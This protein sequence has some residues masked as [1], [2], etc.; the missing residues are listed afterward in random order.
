MTPPETLRRG[1]IFRAEHD[2]SYAFWKSGGARWKLCLS[3]GSAPVEAAGDVHYFSSTSKVNYFRENPHLHSEVL[4]LKPG[5]YSFFPE[6][7]AID[8]RELRIVPMAKLQANGLEV[9]GHL[10]VEDIQRCESII[11]AGRLLS[12]RD[13]RLLDLLG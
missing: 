1:S 6:E 5:V 12:N 11:R 8:F 7:T 2:S 4:I 3:F 10:T 13:R 9:L